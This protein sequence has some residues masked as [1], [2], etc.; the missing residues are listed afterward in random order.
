MWLFVRRQAGGRVMIVRG[1][2]RLRKA[3]LLETDSRREEGTVQ[4]ADDLSIH[5]LSLDDFAE[6]QRR[7]GDDDDD[8]DESMDVS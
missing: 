6:Y 3:K 4:I 2:H 8:D 1:P 5:R 7:A